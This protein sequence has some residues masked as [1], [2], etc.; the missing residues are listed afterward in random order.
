MFSSL[1]LVMRAICH[2]F[3][4]QYQLYQNIARP[5][6]PWTAGIKVNDHMPFHLVGLPKGQSRAL[7]GMI[8]KAW[9]A[10]TQ[11]V[12]VIGLPLDGVLRERM[13]IIFEGEDILEDI[14][15]GVLSGQMS[16][17]IE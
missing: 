5:F 8:V 7:R 1:T 2:L 11:Q 12:L 15:Q 17:A 14:D 6:T 16:F 4:G 13:F 10:D 9:I 3:K